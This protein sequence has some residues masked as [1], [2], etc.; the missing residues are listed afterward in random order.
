[1]AFILVF[2]LSLSL[3]ACGGGEKTASEGKTSE[4]NVEEKKV[5]TFGGPLDGVGNL[6]I[7]LTTINEIFQITT[8]I[9]EGL[10][11]LDAETLEVEP[12]LLAKMPEV[13][14]DGLTYS[15]ELKPDVKF[16]DGT[17]L[18]SNDVKY[19]F[20]RIFTPSAKNVNTW[21]CD[22]ILG[23]KDMLDGK[24]EEL[25]GF[26]I[27]DDTHFEITLQEPYS[28]FMSVLAASQMVI[29][30]EKACEEA[31]DDWGGKVFIG[32]GPYKVKEFVPKNKVVLERYEEYHGGAKK[33]DEIVFLNMDP[34]TALLEFENGTIDVTALDVSLVDN[35]AQDDNFKDNVKKCESLGIVTLG[36]NKSMKPL[37]DARVREAVSLAVDRKGLTENYL[38]GKAVPATCFIPKGIPGYDESAPEFEYNPEKAKQ[39]L[40]EA[41]YPD[42]IELTVIISEKAV[43]APILEVLQQQFKESNIDLTIQKVDHAASLDIGRRGEK[44][45]SIINW[46]ADIIDADNFFYSIP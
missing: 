38:R 30:P 40:S 2:V 16:H 28:A 8:H 14:E 31:G 33:L 12:I 13:S 18:T 25:E 39:L 45:V 44:Q 36:L 20:E 29:Y 35:Y 26:K 46:Y 41:G 10:L 5:L 34:N 3:V 6:D 9:Q 1:M 23:G 19:T 24:T 27:I 37:D 32:T 17:V 21:L 4:A 11:G 43:L 7:H 42:G 22:M 15:C